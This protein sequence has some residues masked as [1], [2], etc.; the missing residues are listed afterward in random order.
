MRLK[1]RA[2]AAEQAARPTSRPARA[3]ALRPR[4]PGDDQ[5]YGE[6]GCRQYV[7]ALNLTETQQEQVSAI[8][9]RMQERRDR[10]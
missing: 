5:A 3:R 1:D 2:T 10:W 7:G 4:S 8:R 9:E 6:N